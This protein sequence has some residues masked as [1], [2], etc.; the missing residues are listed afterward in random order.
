MYMREV[1]KMMF[2]KD[3]E[4][5]QLQMAGIQVHSTTVFSTVMANS[6]GKTEASTEDTTR[7]ELVKVMESTTMETVK[8]FAEVFGE[9]VYWKA[10]ASTKSQEAPQTGL[11]GEKARSRL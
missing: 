5:L 4:F 7:E 10:K 11:F 9:E 2:L 6:T 1:S 3:K 8:V